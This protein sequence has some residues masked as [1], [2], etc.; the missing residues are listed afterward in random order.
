MT[1]LTATCRA[2]MWRRKRKN[3]VH[4]PQAAGVDG[5]VTPRKLIGSALA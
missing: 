5:C 1:S 4:A 3:A 2:G